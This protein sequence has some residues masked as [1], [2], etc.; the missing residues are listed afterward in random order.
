M[1]GKSL[2][3][4]NRASQLAPPTSAWD[5]RLRSRSSK[6]PNEEASLNKRSSVSIQRSSICILTRIGYD[7][8]AGRNRSYGH[9]RR[10]EIRLCNAFLAQAHL[11]RNVEE[12]TR[13]E[14]LPKVPQAGHDD[15][16]HGHADIGPSL[17]KN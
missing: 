15:S 8:N 9:R 1:D 17:V 10:I 14:A 2:A 12:A 11:D 6:S 3:R 13:R 7:R 16:G 5:M 4:F